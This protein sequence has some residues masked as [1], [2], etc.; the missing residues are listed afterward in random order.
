MT[1]ESAIYKKGVKLAKEMFGSESGE[2]GNLPLAE[3]DDL[4]KELVS[5]LYGYLMQ[6]RPGLDMRLKCL[7]AI[8]MLTVLQREDMLVDWVKTALKQGC[9]KE[10]VREVIVS[11]GIYAGWPVA[12]RGLIVTGKLLK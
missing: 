10:E 9:T 2:F 6:E 12:R 4:D 8:S 11:M 7:S 3:G 5:Y 1:E